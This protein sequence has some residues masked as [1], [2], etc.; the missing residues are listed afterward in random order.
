MIECK[1]VI[2]TDLK[3]RGT[4]NVDNPI[5]NIIQV[6]DKDGTLIAEHD[7]SPAKEF[8]KMDLVHFGR[9]LMEN[10]KKVNWKPNEITNQ[11]VDNWLKTLEEK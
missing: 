4:G 8:V 1:E 9:W 5:R 10:R 7:P 6:Y 11:Q 2:I 3:T